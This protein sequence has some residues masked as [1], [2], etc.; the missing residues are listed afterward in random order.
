MLELAQGMESSGRGGKKV[1]TIQGK[2]DAFHLLR[3]GDFRIMYEVVENDQV[4]LVLGIVNRSEL[5]SWLR[6]R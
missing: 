6:N 2:T 4:L 3:V 5:E 1:K